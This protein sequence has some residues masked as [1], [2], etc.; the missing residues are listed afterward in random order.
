MICVKCAVLALYYETVT[1]G[2]GIA[3]RT[4]IPQQ[5]SDQE[6]MM[7]TDVQDKAKPSGKAD[8]YYQ[9]PVLRDREWDQAKQAPWWLTA[10]VVAIVIAAFF[11]GAYAGAPYNLIGWIVGLVAILIYVALGSQRRLRARRR[12][13]EVHAQR[14]A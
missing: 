7:A 2:G 8:R 3:A 9:N 4:G 1:T 6:A 10:V 11:V 13:R 14:A 5:I 12:L